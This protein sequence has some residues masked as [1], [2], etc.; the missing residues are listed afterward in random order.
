MTQAN[1]DIFVDLLVIGCGAA[2]TSAALRAAQAGLSVAVLSNA[3]NPLES[4]S[5]YAQGGIVARPP[6]DTPEELVTRLRDHNEQ[7]EAQN[8]L[9]P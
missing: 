6:G 5:D 1:Q 3:A 9:Q 2:G 4:N 7:L 8:P